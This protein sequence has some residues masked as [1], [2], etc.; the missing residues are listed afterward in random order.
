MSLAGQYLRLQLLIVLAVL[1]AVVA[2]SL[3]QS[4]AAFE[5]VEGRRA[6]S[7]AETLA[8]NPAVRSLLPDAQP[9]GNSVLP[10]V[11]EAVRTISG[12]SQVAWHGPTGR[13]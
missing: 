11:S 8:A 12:S 2:I 1:V 13:W 5:R 10:S 6:L 4:A 7:A 3:A 9:Q